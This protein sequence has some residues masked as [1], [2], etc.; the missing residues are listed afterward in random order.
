MLITTECKNYPI[1]G[2]DRPLG[3]QQVEVPRISRHSVNEGGK[4]VSPVHWPPLPARRY[5][6]CSFLLEAQLTPGHS[7]ASKIRSMKNPSNPTS[8]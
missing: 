5:P 1:T 4:V 6:W 2:L 7:A 8:N 3:L